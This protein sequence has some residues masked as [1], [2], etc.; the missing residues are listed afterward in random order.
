MDYRKLRAWIYGVLV[1]AGPLA[2]FYG[3]LTNEEIVL[4]LG[5]GG[6]LLG[7]P[8]GTVAAANLTPA[9]KEQD[10][11]P[12]QIN[13]VPDG[14]ELL[15]T[16]SD[17]AVDSFEEEGDDEVDAVVEDSEELD[18]ALRAAMNAAGKYGG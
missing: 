13:I 6:T 3:L 12:T 16:T 5:L 11:V 4:W 10:A 9:K 1:A 14:G 7:V 17:A 18:A 8:A 2:S 15:A